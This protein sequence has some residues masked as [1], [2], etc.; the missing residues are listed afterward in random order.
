M[1]LASSFVLTLCRSAGAD[2]YRAP[3]YGWNYG[4]IES[5]R[6]LAMGGAS[7][8]WGWSTSAI[9]ANPANTVAQHVYHFEGLF[10]MDTTA[11]RLTFGAGVLDSATSRVSLGL[12]AVKNDIGND[13]DPYQRHAIDV[14]A[15]AAYPLSDRF[16]FGVT[17]R[18]LSVKQDGSGPLGASPVSQ[19][20]GDPNFQN[21]T[22]DAGLTATPVE[23]LRLS[24]VG[25]NLTATGNPLAP[26]MLAGGVGLKLGDFTAEVDGI[27]VDATTWGSWKARVQ[28]GAELLVADRFPI[29]AGYGY[30][31]GT[32]RHS[33]SFGAGY[34][35][36]QFAV[37]GG[38]RTEVAGPSDPWGKALVFVVGLRYFLDL[39]SQEQAPPLASGS[40]GGPRPG[41]A[42]F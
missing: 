40:M 35:D 23:S 13:S 4:E 9:A 1:A 2:P 37:D 5:P 6:T 39:S 27:G 38:F 33:V 7:R 26:L 22:F 34:V 30:D 25:Y 8:A 3:E 42:T 21:F 28:V 10:G 12:L 29:R 17:G 11:H 14:R 18:Y 36:K 20:S 15:A 16:S 24:L 32:R 41:A 31:D 19:G